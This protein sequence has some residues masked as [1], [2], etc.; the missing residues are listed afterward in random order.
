MI[1]MQRFLTP[2]SARIQSQATEQKTE[3]YTCG[4]SSV[5][6][7]HQ[8]PAQRDIVPDRAAL[9]PREVGE[10]VYIE[11]VQISWSGYDKLIT[12]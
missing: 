9:W 5:Q 4:T 1:P 10:Y 7:L 6:W 8:F 3:Y 11:R 12:R 2:F